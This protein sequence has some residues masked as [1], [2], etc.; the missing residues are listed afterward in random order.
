MFNIFS[1]SPFFEGNETRWSVL[2]TDY[3]SL[4][5]ILYIN[6]YSIGTYFNMLLYP[7]Y[8]EM[9]EQNVAK[10]A[11]RLCFMYIL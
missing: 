6:M 10:A 5:Y 4:T 1:V 2:S 11:D 9:A 8:F 7:V 3:I